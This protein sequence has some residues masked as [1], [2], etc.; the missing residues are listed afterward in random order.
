MKSHIIRRLV[1]GSAILTTMFVLRGAGQDSQVK[2]PSASDAAKPAAVAAKSPASPAVADI[3]K[4]LDAGVSKDVVKAYIE[5][6]LVG[7]QP[8]AADIIAL[9]EHG[10][11][12]EVTTVLLKR[13]PETGASAAQSAASIVAAQAALNPAPG[14]AAPTYVA[15]E[16]YGRLDPEGYNYFQYYYLYPRTLAWANQQLGYYP[17]LNNGWNYGWNGPMPFNPYPPSVFVRSRPLGIRGAAP[18]NRQA[19]QFSR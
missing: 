9:K 6:T 7:Y 14:N 3:V 5:K 1:A 8:S 13:T 12:D 10:V 4:L 17:P 15:G 18:L 16:D 11:S 19:V 2:A